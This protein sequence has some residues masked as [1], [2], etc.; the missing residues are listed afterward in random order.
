VIDDVRFY[1]RALTAAEVDALY[2]AAGQTSAAKAPAA[3]A[4]PWKPIFDGKTMSSINSACLNAWQLK[5]GSIVHVSG[6]DN[7]A[8]TNEDFGDGDLRLRL[9]SRG[10]SVMWF[11]VRQSGA[12]GYRLGLAEHL[13]GELNKG[14]HEVVFSMRGASVTATVD[15]KP[16]RMDPIGAPP[17]RGVVQ[18]NCTVDGGLRIQSIE[19]RDA[20]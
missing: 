6:I 17:V 1:N 18:F 11:I 7:A 12:N 9:E 15:G 3:D 4:R 5:D 20:K 13:Q 8:Q 19:F 2:R 10:N 16:A 14:E